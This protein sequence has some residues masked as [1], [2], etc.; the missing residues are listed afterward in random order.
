MKGSR[1]ETGGIKRLQIMIVIIDRGK[2]AHVERLLRECGVTY[3]MIAPG[4]GA[5][6]KALADI[7]GLTDFERDI[8]ISVVQEGRA[9]DVLDRLRFRFD[10]GRPDS[11]IAFTIPISGVSGPLALKYISGI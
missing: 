5:S 8:V 10:L 2:G 7:L 3:N 11:G 9:H 6:G 1:P 4:S